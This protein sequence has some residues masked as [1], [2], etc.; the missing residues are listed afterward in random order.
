MLHFILTLLNH[1]PKFPQWSTH[2]EELQKHTLAW[3]PS[4]AS[5]VSD[6]M[7]LAWWT[8]HNFAFGN[9]SELILNKKNPHQCKPET[10]QGP[11]RWELQ[12]MTRVFVVLVWRISSANQLPCVLIPRQN[13][14]SGQSYSCLQRWFL[15]ILFDVS[16]FFTSSPSDKS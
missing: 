15:T 3:S 16:K 4:M 1:L 11:E 14:P 7:P 13:I 12:K 10:E 8:S 6:Q 9:F 2:N 5:K